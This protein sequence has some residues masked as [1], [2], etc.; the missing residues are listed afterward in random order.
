MKKSEKP[1]ELEQLLQ[2]IQLSSLASQP[3]LEQQKIEDS[4]KGQ[5][6][7][8]ALDM[9]GLQ[10]SMSAEQA[11]NLLAQQQMRQSGELAERGFGLQEAGQRQAGQLG[12]QEIGLKTEANTLARD[13]M[14]QEGDIATKNFAQEDKKLT[15]QQNL[16]DLEAATRLFGNPQLGKGA[17]EQI[18]ALSPKVGAMV[19]KGRAADLE[20]T[21]NSTILPMVQKLHDKKESKPL[22]DYLGELPVEQLHPALSYLGLGNIQGKNTKR[23]LPNAKAMYEAKNGLVKG[24]PWNYGENTTSTNDQPQYVSGGGPSF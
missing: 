19:T 6:L 20:D 23:D 15:Q 1:G 5:D 11:R 7:Q 13:R 21:M 9:L 16:G 22:F 17:M 14:L 2:L 12:Q 8:A 4:R 18:G 10:N 24:S 3:Q